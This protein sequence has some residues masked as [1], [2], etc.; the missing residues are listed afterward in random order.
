MCWQRVRRPCHCSPYRHPWNPHNVSE[1]GPVIILIL[2]KRKWG[3]LGK[4]TY[5]GH[6]ARKLL[7]ICHISIAS[8]NT[9][10]FV[11]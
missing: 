6:S 10:R 4:V 8:S 5:Q 1:A 9:Y 3:L 2:Q 7:L 11:F